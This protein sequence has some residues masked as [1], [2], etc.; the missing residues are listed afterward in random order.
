M[1]MT[2]Y[3]VAL[4]AICA[5]FVLSG[6]PDTYLP[7]LFFWVAVIAAANMAE[8]SMTRQLETDAT[9]G[10]IV[11]VASA[12][13]Y[14]PGAVVLFAFVGAL[15]RRELRGQAPVV[16]AVFNRAMMALC[17]AVAAL[18]A[19]AVEAAIGTAPWVIVPAALVASLSFDAT[20]T[21]LLATMLVVRR[22][23]SWAGAFRHV[24]NPFPRYTMNAAVSTMLS[25][26]VFVLVEDV[27][28]WAILLIAIPLWLS[29][30][31]Q[32][33]AREAQDRADQLAARV[34]ELQMLNALS[35]ELLSVR[36]VE[37]V[38][39]LAS[40]ALEEQYGEGVVIDLDGSLDAPD[41]ER[42]AI[43][44]VDHA[45]IVV[46]NGAAQPRA[47]IE[48]LASLVGLTLSRLELE[49]ELA[50][51]ER[52]RTVLTGRILEEATHE[53]SRIAMA[54]HDDVLPL[55][56]AAQMQ[57]DNVDM[58]LELQDL[59][60]AT[61]TVEQ[62]TTGVSDGIRALR[63]TLET[64]RESTL[65]PGTIVDGVRGLMADFQARTG[66]RSHV[67][68]P[69]TMPD[70]PFAIELLAYETLRGCLANVEKHSRA[71]TVH[72]EFQVDKARLV[73]LMQDDGRGFDPTAI[74][75]RSHGLALMQQRA[76]LARGSFDIT[77]AP[78]AGTTVRLEVPTW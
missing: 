36:D 19:A 57:I 44:G 32:R 55:F 39:P 14:D 42:V 3:A 28:R 46:N 78:D 69:D 33:S 66:I 21:V 4:T 72:V 20:N 26:L 74:G 61:A 49:R 73:V 48:A 29:H 37:S 27:S 58:M 56:A 9:L 53:R 24:L 62:A 7:D 75:K 12:L 6:D 50:A 67:E 65:V 11:I 76:E 34:R 16:M 77:G 17:G 47:V 30:S 54:V 35:A 10:S 5:A 22:G 31:A 40:H 41:D 51:T 23:Q 68:A 2:L 70:L 63:D 13:I 43:N 1:R 60:R 45:T 18:G 25:L 52:A 8:V 59:D 71:T 38:V 15:H 64:L